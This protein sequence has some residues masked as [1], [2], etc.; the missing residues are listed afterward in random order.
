[1]NAS[2]AGALTPAPRPRSEDRARADLSCEAQNTRSPKKPM[3]RSSA[4][5]PDPQRSRDAPG[6]A[7]RV[8]ANLSSAD[9]RCNGCRARFGL[10]NMRQPHSSRRTTEADM[11]AW[12]RVID[13]RTGA[14]A[15]AQTPPCAPA[16]TTRWDATPSVELTWVPEMVS[17]VSTFSMLTSW[18]PTKTSRWRMKGQPAARWNRTGE[19]ARRV[20]TRQRSLHMLDAI[21]VAQEIFCEVRCRPEDA[22]G[23]GVD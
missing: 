1:V 23:Q 9:R 8:G 15:R 20:G 14:V 6:S 17:L 21:S 19:R 18:Q 10:P 13:V 2:V 7:L 11:S 4:V 5:L 12:S 3:M 16:V 22:I